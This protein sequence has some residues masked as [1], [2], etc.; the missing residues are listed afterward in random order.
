M[1]LIIFSPLLPWL[2]PGTTD[3][4]ESG[5][6]VDHQVWTSQGH[7]LLAFTV[8]HGRGAKSSDSKAHCLGLNPNTAPSSVI[9]NKLLKLCSLIS[10]PVKWR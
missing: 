8:Q 5:Q 6:Y 10:S 9:L 7:I 4:P 1:A 3:I 2:V